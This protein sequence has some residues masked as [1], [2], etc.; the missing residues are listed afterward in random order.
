MGNEIVKW[1]C[2]ALYLL[3]GGVSMFMGLWT[4]RKLGLKRNDVDYW[5]AL[6]TA[7][8]GA[9]VFGIYFVLMWAPVT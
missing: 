8:C 9:I 1:L 5:I 6:G 3:L 2:I 4:I 7:A